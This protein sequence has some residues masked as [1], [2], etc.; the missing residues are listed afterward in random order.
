[1]YAQEPYQVG[2]VL[3]GA[4]AIGGLVVAPAIIG[5]RGLMRRGWTDHQLTLA[6][7][8]VLVVIIGF[9]M[10]LPAAVKPK[11]VAHL[12]TLNLQNAAIRH[13]VLFACER[14][15]DTGYMVNYQVQGAT[16]L[17]RLCWRVTGGD[18]IWRPNTDLPSKF[19]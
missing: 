9:L 16:R 15:L 14:T 6:T 8:S 11:A 5:V 1:V 3:L 19:P 7:A 4:G 10:W 2:L 17:G 18:W 13:V 12:Q